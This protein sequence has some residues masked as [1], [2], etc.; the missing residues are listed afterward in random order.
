[1]TS[2]WL[3]RRCRAASAVGLV[4]TR[5]ETG[6]CRPGLYTICIRKRLLSPVLKVIRLTRLGGFT[7]QHSG[8]T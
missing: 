1:M 6:P 7:V 4:Q 2:R 3:S 8:V 5:S